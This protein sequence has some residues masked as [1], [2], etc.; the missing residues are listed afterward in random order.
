MGRSATGVRGIKL[1]DGDAVVDMVITDD[2][3]SLLTICANG[4]GKRTAVSEYRLQGRGGMGTIDIRTTERNGKV[5][6][7]LAVS[8][9]DDIMVVTKDGQIV[10][11]PAGGISTIGRATQGVRCIALNEGDQVVSAAKIASEDVV[12][13]ADETR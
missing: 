10:R 6:N 9:T 4:Y 2:T 13:G 8:E 7:L 11:T 3:R 12:P 1:R 5:V